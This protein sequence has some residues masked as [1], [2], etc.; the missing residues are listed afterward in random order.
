MSDRNQKRLLAS[1]HE[2]NL[3]GMNDLISKE[4]IEVLEK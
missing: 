2:G 1:V 4:I 3:K